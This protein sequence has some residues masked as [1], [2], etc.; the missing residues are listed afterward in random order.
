M[1]LENLTWPEVKKLKLANQVGVLPPGSFKQ[2]G[3]HGRSRPNWHR[4]GRDG[5]VDEFVDW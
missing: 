4:E 3:P 1:L 5:V 2:H